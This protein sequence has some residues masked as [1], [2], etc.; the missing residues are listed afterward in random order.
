MCY[1]PPCAFLSYL[2]AQTL[3]DWGLSLVSVVGRLRRAL[4]EELWRLH[5]A[6]CHA[7][8]TI[9]ICSLSSTYFSQ[10]FCA[11]VGCSTADV[12]ILKYFH[13]NGKWVILKEDLQVVRESVTSSRKKRQVLMLRPLIEWFIQDGSQRYFVFL[14]G[15]SEEVANPL[16]T[17][18]SQL[19]PA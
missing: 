10:H 5:I 8:L 16:E 12:F 4:D 18:L 14:D 7:S 3:R 11:V 13:F 9:L 15:E 19:I 1:R 6:L 2:S 17:Y